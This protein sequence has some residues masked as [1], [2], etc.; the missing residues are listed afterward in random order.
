MKPKIKIILTDDH[1]IF[2]DGIKSLLSEN[3]TIQIVGE[4]SN[5]IEL[6][7]MLKV[8]TPD[9]VIMDITMPKI[10]GIEV[11]KQFMLTKTISCKN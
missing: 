5:G 6:M 2:R 8:N 1:R 10:S 11:A 9:M 3:D 7:E 4:A